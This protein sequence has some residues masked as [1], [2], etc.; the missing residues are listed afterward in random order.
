MNSQYIE[1]GKKDRKKNTHQ[2]EMR[3]QKKK[4]NPNIKRDTRLKKARK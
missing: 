4:L 3:E 2:L 1:N